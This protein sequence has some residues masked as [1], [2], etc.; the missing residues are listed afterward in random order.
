MQIIIQDLEEL[1]RQFGDKLDT[2]SD[3]DFHSKPNPAKWSKIEVLGHLI[4]SS[5][6]N[7]RR[8]ICCQYESTP[9]LIVYDQDFWVAAN[10]YQSAKKESI[11]QLWILL[12]ERICSILLS[13]EQSSYNKNCNTGRE[14][15]HLHSIEWLAGDY[16]KHMKHHLN[17]I[18][19]GSFNII[20][21]G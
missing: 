9:P 1:I 3:S 18:I 5:Q 21:P 12:N 10:N 11:I 15:P 6:N 8:F 20:Y 2:I 4:D 19:P 13:M 7:L 14:I 17:Q 16:V